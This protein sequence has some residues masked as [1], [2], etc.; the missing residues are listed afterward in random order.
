M[1][2][3]CFLESTAMISN[4]I[5]NVGQSLVHESTHLKKFSSSQISFNRNFAYLTLSGESVSQMNSVSLQSQSH[6]QQILDCGFEYTTLQTVMTDFF[7][8]SCHDTLMHSTSSPG[9][10]CL[11]ALTC[12]LFP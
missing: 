1:W 4:M 2:L 3:L 10:S 11:P 5:T 12:F 9:L 6:M 7:G 8:L